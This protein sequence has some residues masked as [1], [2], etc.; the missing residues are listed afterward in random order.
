MG[1]AV[2]QRSSLCPLLSPF[3]NLVVSADACHLPE[4]LTPPKFSREALLSAR[5]SSRRFTT[6]RMEF[7]NSFPKPA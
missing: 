7:Q 5:A 6:R 2:A 1:L 3:A 4:K